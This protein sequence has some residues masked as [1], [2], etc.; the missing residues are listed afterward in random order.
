MS[1]RSFR[2]GIGTDVHR[3]AEDDRPLHLACL[4]WPGE[5]GIE[6]HSDGDVAAHAVCDAL[7]AAASLGDLGTIFGTNRPEMTGASGA[8]MLAE[9]LRRLRAAR[10][11]VANVS[12][13]IIGNRPKVGTR[14]DEARDAM[15]A[16]LGGC[17]VSVSATTTDGLGLTGRGEG[18]AAIATGLLSLSR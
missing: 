9:V 17:P 5:R 18:L 3:Y 15:S 14:R 4:V 11:G 16:V 12:V 2:V 7:L 8:D 6:G 10:W 1:D 13:Q